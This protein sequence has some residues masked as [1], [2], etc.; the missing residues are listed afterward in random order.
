MR[1]LDTI[2]VHCA[3][4]PETMDIGVNEIR[5]WHVTD[6]GWTDIGYHYVIRRNGTVEE[7]RPLKVAGAHCYGHNSTSIGICLVGRDKFNPEQFKAL[8]KLVTGLKKE[9]KIS[10]VKGH[11]EY[12]E[13]KTCPN[14]NIK[15][16][17]MKIK[18]SKESAKDALVVLKD[19]VIKPMTK[20]RLIVLALIACLAAVGI[21]LDESSATVLVELG[22]SVI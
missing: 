6:N 3:D 2:I 10:V 8:Y 21:N 12:D 22:M 11:N 20:K 17:M 14:F 4:T 15:D 9:F 7:G 18:F 16:E 13:H 1:V 5:Q 19:K